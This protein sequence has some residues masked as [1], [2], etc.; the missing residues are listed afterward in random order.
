[1]NEQDHAAAVFMNKDSFGRIKITASRWRGITAGPHGFT[2]IELL[3]VVAVLG[4]LVTLAIPSYNQMVNGAKTSRAREEIRTIEKSI[5]TWTLDRAIGTY[6]PDLTAVG[7]GNTLDPW[8]HPYRYRLATSA[9]GAPRLDYYRIPL[10]PGDYDL[11]SLGPNAITDEDTG[12]VTTAPSGDDI[13]R[14]GNGGD[15]ALGASF[16]P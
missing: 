6:P 9:T 2:L 14:A 3:V 7:H 12:D 5:T 4:I 15:V 10:N 1:M 11:Y 13:L 16:K 8:G